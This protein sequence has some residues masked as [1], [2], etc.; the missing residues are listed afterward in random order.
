[1]TMS[2]I[3]LVMWSIFLVL[4]PFHV[5]GKDPVLK[6]EDPR[7]LS[8]KVEGGMPQPADFFMLLIMATVFT[9]VGV[10]L[11]PW[12]VRVAAAFGAFATY[13][14][15]IGLSWGA[16]LGEVA[17]VKGMLF[18]PYNCLLLLTFLVLYGRYKEEV[19]RYT[20]HAVAASVFLQVIL[21]PLTSDP[22]VTR[23]QFC[24]NHCNQL[25]YYGVVAA[26]IFA[27]G[28][29]YFRVGMAYRV[30]FYAAVTYVTCVTLSK[31]AIGALAVLLILVFLRRPMGLLVGGLLLA[32]SLLVMFSLPPG[33][34]PQLV[35]DLERR[36]TKVESDETAEKRGYDRIVNHPQHLFLGA[37]EGVTHR[38]MSEW[39]GE[40]H[41][42][43]GT[44][45]FSYGVIGT[46]LFGYGLW[47]VLRAN[48]GLGI[49]LLPAGLFGL[50]HQGLRFTMFWVLVGFIGCLAR[51]CR[52]G[53]ISQEVEVRQ[54]AEVAELLPLGPAH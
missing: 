34:S 5:L 4:I 38:F 20:M 31:A 3:H 43:P 30:C 1:M 11:E 28:S 8:N 41:S 10:R 53:F 42:S 27:L 6:K 45:L 50:I 49:Y 18:Y 37:A 47:L 25:G 16:W 32:V 44:L 15:L 7:H 35:A 29:R 21:S 23:Q 2:R 17:P 51:S 39:P 48:G 24:F 13:A 19:L 52:S 46:A 33:L 9:S 36:F 22:S 12:A 14:A 26:S 40:L 54:S